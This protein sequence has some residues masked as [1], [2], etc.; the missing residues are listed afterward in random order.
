MEDRASQEYI[1]PEKA[2]EDDKQ[3]EGDPDEEGDDDKQ[4]E[5]P[6]VWKFICYHRS[7]KEGDWYCG[8]CDSAVEGFAKA[9]QKW[10]KC[11]RIVLDVAEKDAIANDWNKTF[12][13][14]LQHDKPRFVIMIRNFKIQCDQGDVRSG[15][16]S[17]RRSS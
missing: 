11:C 16:S 15:R 9:R 14:V 8:V 1:I 12:N 6:C 7:D 4:Q 2:D 10:P 17:R 3:Q 5:D 13:E